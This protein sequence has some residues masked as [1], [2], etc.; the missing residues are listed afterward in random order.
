MTDV[1]LDCLT[2][3]L[4]GSFLQPGLIFA[5]HEFIST[6]VAK[7]QPSETHADWMYLDSKTVLQQ[8]P[9]KYIVR[10][11]ETPTLELDPTITVPASPEVEDSGVPF[12]LCSSTT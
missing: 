12:G 3:F 11:A 8:F 6:V 10:P 9:T 7:H 1:I 2:D 5:A 4:P